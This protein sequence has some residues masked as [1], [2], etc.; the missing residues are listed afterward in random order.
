MRQCCILILRNIA[1][2]IIGSFKTTEMWHQVRKT[3][4][5]R[6]LV[7]P[8]RIQLPKSKERKALYKNVRSCSNH[9]AS[10]AYCSRR[11]LKHMR[12]TTICIQYLAKDCCSCLGC[13]Y[14]FFYKNG[15]SVH[16]K[17]LDDFVSFAAKT[18]GTGIQFLDD[19][20]LYI[21]FRGRCIPVK[22]RKG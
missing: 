16:Y 20:G 14:K 18:N 19:N 10:Q 11:N 7:S 1:K 13:G 4:R 6:E 21:K 2:H 8:L 12:N 9:M 5:Y 15:K 22:L 17:K 3:R